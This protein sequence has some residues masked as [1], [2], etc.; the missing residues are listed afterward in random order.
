MK[1]ALYKYKMHISKKFK[2]SHRLTAAL[3]LVMKRGRMARR[4]FVFLTE[5][6]LLKTKLVLITNTDHLLISLQLHMVSFL[7]QFNFWFYF[8]IRRMVQREN[9]SN[10]CSAQRKIPTTVFEYYLLCSRKFRIYY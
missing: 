7:I 10:V 5:D 9:Y 6:L 8:M 3:L 4:T 1:S 2:F